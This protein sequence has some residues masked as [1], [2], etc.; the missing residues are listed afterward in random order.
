MGRSNRS[1][2]EW[3]ADGIQRLKIVGDPHGEFCG[4]HSA[5]LIPN[6]HLLL[7]DN[8]NHCLEDPETGDTQR[9]NREFSRVVEYALDPDNGEA[10]FVRQHCQGNTLYSVFDILR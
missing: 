5:R 7:F 1:D 10:V 4:Q 3:E 8:G 2:A 9:P 6:G